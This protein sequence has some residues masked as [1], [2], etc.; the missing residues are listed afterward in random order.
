MADEGVGLRRGVSVLG[1][2]GGSISASSVDR[3]H[4]S[5]RT[6]VAVGMLAMY[7]GCLW[8]ASEGC[9]RFHEARG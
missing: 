1:V 8:G 5:L 6:M 4:G 3:F 7:N 9:V 2:D